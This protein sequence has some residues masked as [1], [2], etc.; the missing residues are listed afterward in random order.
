MAPAGAIVRSPDHILDKVTGESREVDASIRY[1]VGTSLVLITIECRDR[2]SVEDVRWIEQLAEKQRSIGASATVA[3]SSSGFSQPA[4]IK[5]NAVGIQVR[6]LTD[7]TAD[8]FVQWLKFQNVRL[9]INEWALAQVDLELYDAAE[10]S[11]LSPES[12]E[13][14]RQHGP[15]API[16]I[17]NSD[18][19]RY[20]IENILLE[21][22][23]RNGSFFPRDL[24]SDGTKVRRNL[25]QPL[26][27]DVLHVETT[28]GKYDVRIINIG[29]LLSRSRSQVPLARLAEYA[30]ADSTLVQT[31]EWTLQPSM[32]LSV[33]RDLTSGVTEVRLTKDDISAC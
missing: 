31:A 7:A 8:D 28:K 4:I 20:H 18:G 3:V 13:L 22:E 2:T 21:W 14:F 10:D 29:L 5:A 33:H 17:R 30:D 24:R 27:R 1:K 12:Q 11:E 15:L 26:D 32:T 16:L 25:H 6:V 23:K 19:R 9:D